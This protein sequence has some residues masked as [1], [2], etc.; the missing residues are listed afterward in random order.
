M[1]LKQGGRSVHDYSKQFIHL[2]QYAP[3]QVDTDKKKDRFMI[4]LSTKLQENMALNTGGTFLEFVSNVMIADDAIYAHRETK[5]R[6]DVAAPSGSAHLKY[7]TVYHYGSTY[8]PQQPQQHQHQRQPQ[9]WAPRP[10]Q[11]QHQ[12][13][14]PKALPPLP[15]VIRLPVPPTARATSGHTYF[16]CGRSSH[17]ARKCTVPK[18]NVTQGHVTHAPRGLQKVAVVKTGC[19]N[20]TTMEDVPE[21]EQVLASMFSL[22]GHPIVILFYSGATHNFISKAC[23]KSYWLTITHISTPY[24]I[25]TPEGKTVTQYLAKNTP[26]NLGGEVYKIGLIILDG[27]GI[28]V[29]LGMSWMKEFKALLD[30][31]TRTVHLES[32]AHGSVVQKLPSPTSIAST[33]HHTAAQNLEDIPMTCK[34]PDVFPKDLPGMPPDRYV[35]FTIELHPD[36]APISRQP[37]KMT[38]KELVELKVQSN[39]L[40]DKGYIHP[41]SSP[42]GCPALFVKKKDQSLRLCVDY[43]PLNTITV[44]NKYPLPR[45]DILFYQ[46]ASAKVFSKVDLCSGYHQIKICSKTFLRPLSPPGMGCMSIWL[47]LDSPMLLHISCT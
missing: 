22:N 41:S 32:P 34:F 30:I 46:L 45:I 20:Y 29:I 21:G 8:P 7:R 24:M 40:L 14:A 26:L 44:K 23:T 38:P 18:K 4:G 42:W 47:S 11:R 25:S 12:Q 43:Q 31:A 35:E 3:D 10:P 15:T 33:L 6:K 28:D 37:Y 13:V 9:Q 36:T 5:K 17:F 19:I 2:A 39:E 27:Q 1:N 16:N